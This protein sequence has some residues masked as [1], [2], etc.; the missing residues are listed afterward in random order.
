MDQIIIKLFK[1]YIV[2]NEDISIIHYVYLKNYN[3][4]D[5]IYFY[6]NK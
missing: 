3:Y 6:F 2:S 1:Y 5:F 4:I